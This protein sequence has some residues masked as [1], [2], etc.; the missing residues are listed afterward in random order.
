MWV[1]AI[2]YL[3]DTLRDSPT[4]LIMV[5]HDRWFMENLCTQLLELHSGSGYMHSFGGPGSYAGFVEVGYTAHG[6]PWWRS[7]V[8]LSLSLPDQQM[9][10]WVLHGTPWRTP[11]AGERLWPHAR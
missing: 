3:E 7:A 8:L 2:E 10:A 5:T 4:A 1:Q 6:K 9:C 11:Q